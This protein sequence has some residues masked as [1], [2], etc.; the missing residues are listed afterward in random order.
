MNEL[1][2]RQ[3]PQ[4]FHLLLFMAFSYLVEIKRN[5]FFFSNISESYLNED[6]QLFQCLILFSRSSSVPALLLS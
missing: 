5:V 2:K 3:V 4:L 1:F 6:P